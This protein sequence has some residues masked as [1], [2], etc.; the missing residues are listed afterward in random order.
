M[1]TTE[2]VVSGASSLSGA[3]EV[4]ERFQER[5]DEAWAEAVAGENPSTTCAAVKGR[6]VVAEP[7]A[8]DRALAA[9]NVDI[10]VRY[11][12]TYLGRVESGEKSCMDF[13]THMMTTL[14]AMTISTEGFRELAKSGDAADTSDA[15]AVGAGSAILAGEAA[16]GGGVGDPRAAVKERLRDHVTEVCPDQAPVILR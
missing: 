7:G 11:F 8:A 14:P 10:P 2:E 6:A 9:C 1:Q 3:P 12:L 15:A 4:E 5:I 16:A 13:M